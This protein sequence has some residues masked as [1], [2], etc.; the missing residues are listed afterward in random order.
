MNGY[1]I[2]SESI[3]LINRM[4]KLATIK[5]Y[6]QHQKDVHASKRKVKSNSRKKLKRIV[7]KGSEH[8]HLV[9]D[10]AKAGKRKSSDD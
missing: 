4:S 5:L 1:Q 9:D 6:K 10:I 8:K 7:S 3:R 2:V